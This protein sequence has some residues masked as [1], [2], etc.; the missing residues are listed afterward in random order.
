[1]GLQGKSPGD[2]SSH[3]GKPLRGLR[4]NPEGVTEIES[5]HQHY[6]RVRISVLELP[7]QQDVEPLGRQARIVAGDFDRPREIQ[8]TQQGELLPVDLVGVRAAQHVLNPG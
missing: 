5:L 4:D 1:M 2:E 6:G 8:R 7:A 3:V